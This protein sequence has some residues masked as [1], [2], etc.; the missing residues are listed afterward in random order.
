[1]SEI[2]VNRVAAGE[3]I[4]RPA[5]VVKELVENAIDAGAGEICVSFRRAGKDFIAVEDDGSGMAH[6]DALRALERH[7]TSKIAS[8]EDLSAIRSFGFRGEAL[9][10]IASVARLT[11]R[12]RRERDE[13]GTEIVVDDG[14]Q[15]SVREV[16]AAHGTAVRVEHLFQSV[17]ARRKFLRTDQTEANHIVETV[18]SFALTFPQIAF[19]LR[20]GERTIFDV[21]RGDRVSRIRQLWGDVLADLLFRIEAGEGDRRLEWFVARPGY[22]SPTAAPEMLFFVNGRQIRSKD[23][24]EWTLESCAAHFSRCSTLPSFLFLELPPSQVDVNVHPAKREVRFSGRAAL[25]EFLVRELGH[26]LSARNAPIYIAT[27]TRRGPSPSE[28][29]AVPEE[30]HSGER[31]RP[32]SVLEESLQE[33]SCRKD[34]A[35]P[36]PAAASPANSNEGTTNWRYVGSWDPDYALFD[37][38]TGLIFFNVGTATAYLTQ[39]HATAQRPPCQ[40][41]LLTETV[42]SYWGGEDLDI[43]PGD[44]ATD[45]RMRAA[46]MAKTSTQERHATELLGTVLST[47]PSQLPAFC[48]EISRSEI[49]RRFL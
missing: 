45:H 40:G 1:L 18:R 16:I 29:E 14:A 4:E 25:R 10:S 42:P 28:A 27:P 36:A 9:P 5:S 7:A 24:R 43:L 33:D 21:T 6:E 34:R 2:L 31:W 37:S 41:L 38:G 48:C 39:R 49:R 3:V 12:T 19:R 35:P 30:S 44:R 47:A 15:V 8:F 20:H 17:P 23:L 26:G 22:F 11:L 32:A 46:P 13:L